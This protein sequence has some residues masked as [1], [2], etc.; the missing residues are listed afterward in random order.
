MAR[1]SPIA[2]GN[3]YDKNKV[4]SYKVS[5]KK[6]MVES[7]GWTT[8]DELEIKVVDGKIIIEKQEIPT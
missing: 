6:S 1:L 2:S 3:K 4:T 8:E 7:L 5:I